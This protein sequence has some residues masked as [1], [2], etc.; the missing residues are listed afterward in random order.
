[1]KYLDTI[2]VDCKSFIVRSITIFKDTD[3]EVTINVAST[4]LLDYITDENDEI[5]P[6]YVPV[7]NQ[8]SCYV[9]SMDLFRMSDE[10]LIQHVEEDYYDK[11]N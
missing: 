11:K 3:E 1:M 6:E 4:M 7:D 2:E 5:K 10:Q 9:N 8:I